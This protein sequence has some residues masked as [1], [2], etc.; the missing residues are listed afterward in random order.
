MDEIIE[1][2]EKTYPNFKEVKIHKSEENAIVEGAA[3]LAIE[4]YLKKVT[5]G[6]EGENVY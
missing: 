5:V 3:I 1:E 4:L 2:W 6:L